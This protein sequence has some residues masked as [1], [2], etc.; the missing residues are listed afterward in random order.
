MILLIGSTLACAHLG[1]TLCL[2]SAENGQLPQTQPV[3]PQL[4]GLELYVPL[5]NGFP[6]EGY[7]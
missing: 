4:R 6:L 2:S 3:G 1:L 7:R 5:C